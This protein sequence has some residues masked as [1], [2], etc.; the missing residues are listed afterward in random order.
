MRCIGKENPPCDR[1][2]STGRACSFDGPRAS[3]ASR[4]D[5][6][7]ERIVSAEAGKV[8]LTRDCRRLRMVESQ[9]ELFQSGLNEL[10]NMQRGS[11]IGIPAPPPVQDLVLP[12]QLN[13][14]ENDTSSSHVDSL[15]SAHLSRAF[16]LRQASTSNLPHT[17]LE[18]SPS[19]VP[20]LWV[21]PNAQESSAQGSDDEDDGDPLEPSAI[22]RPWESMLSLAEAARL[23]A[24]RQPPNPERSSNPRE[25]AVASHPFDFRV[26]SPTKRRRT[27]D[28]SRFSFHA[29]TDHR[30][31]FPDIVDLGYCTEEKGKQL[32]DLFFDRCSIYVPVFQPDEDTWDSLRKRSPFSITTLI[33]VGAKV[34][35]GGGR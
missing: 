11:Q 34:E 29:P 18:A 26:P 17:A 33:M 25:S 1:C 4:V 32:V 14:A 30:Y 5:E 8:K 23:N 7:V 2:Q 20:N 31:V 6:W 10:L 15:D 35:D 12:L 28:E 16:P 19:S 22:Q 13:P 3:K 27:D 21:Q 24:D 9:M